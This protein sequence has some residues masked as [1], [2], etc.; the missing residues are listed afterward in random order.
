MHRLVCLIALL[1]TGPLHTAAQQ[2]AAGNGAPRV[3]APR[4]GSF[5]ATIQGYALT[6]ANGPLTNATLR[7]R[8]ARSG[9][10]VDM[11]VTDASGLFIFQNVEPGSY[12]VELMGADHSTVLAAS[13]LFHVNA[14][15]AVS[16]VVKL[17]LRIPPFAGLLGASA[18]SSAAAVVAEAA[19]T[20][21]LTVTAPGVLGGPTCPLQ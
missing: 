5:T 14:N 21:L 4:S 18:A 17:P 1:A 7:L 8:D 19:A 15:D 9:R 20:G 16:A 12:V 6:S 2:P 11:R 10:I 3:A 13:D